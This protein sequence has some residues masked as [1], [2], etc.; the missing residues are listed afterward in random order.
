MTGQ[1]NKNPNAHIGVCVCVHMCAH[2]PW[3][4]V[5]R[6]WGRVV[7][8]YITCWGLVA[9]SAVIHFFLCPSEGSVGRK[10]PFLSL[11][12][13]R[14][15]IMTG[16]PLQSHTEGWLRASEPN[17]VVLPSRSTAKR[18]NK[19]MFL[20]C[21]RTSLISEPIKQSKSLRN[22]NAF[23]WK[24]FSVFRNTVIRFMFSLEIHAVRVPAG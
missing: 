1:R 24:S 10:G 6:V 12:D 18:W 5:V 22:N 20:Y 16:Q 21:L 9:N 3:V 13:P 11:L 2:T 17:F 14:E 15:L 23:S 4:N 7:L 19:Q 8:V